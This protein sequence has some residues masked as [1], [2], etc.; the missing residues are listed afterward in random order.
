MVWAVKGNR[1]SQIKDSS[2]FRCNVMTYADFLRS[3]AQIGTFDGFSPRELPSFLFDFQA[4]MVE[5]A[6]RKGRAAIFA[7]CGLGK[8]PMQLAWADQIVRRENG[9]VLILTPL[10]VS[11]QTVREGEK[12]GIEC[13]RTGMARIL[14]TNY[15]RLHLLDPADFVGIVCDE[16]AILKSFEGV[17]RAEITEFMR[18][19]KYRLLCTATPSPNEYVELGT[20]SEALGY[21]GHMDMLARFFK[22]DQGNSIKPHRYR[23]KGKNYS[24][25]DDAGKWRFKGHAELPFWRW[26]CSWAIACRRPSDLGYADAR[27]VLPPLHERIHQVEAARLPEGR[28]FDLPAIGLS[29]QREE[30][31]RTLIERCEQAAALATDD[32]GNPAAVWC[33]LNGEGDLIE[34]LIPDCVQVSGRDSDEAKEEK[35]TAFIEGQTRVLVTKERI[36][37]WGLNFQHCARSISFPTH[38]FEGYYQSIRRFWR[39]GQIRPVV[40]DIITTEGEQSVLANLRRKSMAADQMFSRLIEQMSAAT[41]IDRGMIFCERDGVP[42]WL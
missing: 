20:S 8:T 17:R 31:R 16:S 30:R 3:K 23:D 28:L 22:N 34:S 40:S 33:A 4:H 38:S 32:L 36:G 26:I 42:A 15:E 6:L 41:S 21:L 27:F 9:R 1:E 12:F 5:W 10:A 13:A 19:M 37:A 29:E 24:E 25:L 39:F 35:F 14:V 2:L 18:R 7:D 11:S